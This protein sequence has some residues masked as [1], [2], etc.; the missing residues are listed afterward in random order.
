MMRHGREV[1]LGLI[2]YKPQL[3]QTIV[4]QKWKLEKR[5]LRQRAAYPG[6][7]IQLSSMETVERHRKYRRREQIKNYDVYIWV[8]LY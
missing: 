8:P 1:A 7:S 4:P 6:D 2:K 3:P 5:A